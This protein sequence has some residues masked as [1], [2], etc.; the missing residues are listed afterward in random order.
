MQTKYDELKETLQR[1]TQIVTFTKKDGT[2]REMRCTLQPDLLPPQ[3]DLEETIQEKKVNT[4]VL[5]VWDLEKGAW[6]S[7]RIDAINSV[8]NV[9][10]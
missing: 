3:K 1:E 5:A 2:V 10:E 6:R 7:F 4:E 8:S 9:H